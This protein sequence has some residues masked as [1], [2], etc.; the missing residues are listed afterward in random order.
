MLNVNG[1]RFEF[2]GSKGLVRRSG[3]RVSLRSR[4]VKG[5]KV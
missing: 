4:G 5:V 3:E 2:E 1:E